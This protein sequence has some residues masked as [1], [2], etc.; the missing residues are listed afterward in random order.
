MNKNVLLVDENRPD[1]RSLDHLF[2]SFFGETPFFGLRRAPIP[3]GFTPSVDIRETDAE[4]IVYASLPGLAKE[5]LSLE[6]K[7]DAL[8]LS[9]RL[10][11]LGSDEDAWVRREL[12]RGEFY[13]AFSL[14]AQVDS[15]KARASMKNGILEI[16][17]PKAE[18]AK[19][20]KVEIL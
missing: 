7:N 17:L 9:G 10:K 4:L 8:V 18:E 5:D 2:E 11:P 16:R 13:R 3:Q 6:I 20:R 15:A 1:F 12:P 14:P 19:P